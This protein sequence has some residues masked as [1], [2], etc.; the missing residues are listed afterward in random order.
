MEQIT[1]GA[2]ITALVFILRVSFG[3]KKDHVPLAS[4]GVTFLIFGIYVMA[5]KVK[6]DWSLISTAFAISFTASG[7]W[8]NGKS[9]L[10]IIDDKLKKSKNKKNKKNKKI[11][12][13]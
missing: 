2:I 9:A 10:N 8:N 1:F 4:L 5:E 13:E 3:I 12:R 6:I 11:N 7:I